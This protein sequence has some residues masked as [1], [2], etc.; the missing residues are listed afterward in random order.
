LD[1]NDANWRTTMR[2]LPFA[3]ILIAFLFFDQ[4]D[5]VLIPAP[6]FHGV[7]ITTDDEYLPPER[8]EHRE[9][10]TAA[11]QPAPLGLRPATGLPQRRVLARLDL[12]APHAPPPLHVLMSLQC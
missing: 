2:T 4:I 11:Q 1:G 10:L 12:A 3:S 8:P 6:P 5:D 9:G 7:P